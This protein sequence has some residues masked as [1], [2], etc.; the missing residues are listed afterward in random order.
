[1]QESFALVTYLTAI[2]ASVQLF[3]QFKHVCIDK[4][5]Q[6]QAYLILSKD[7]AWDWTDPMRYTQLE[8]IRVAQLNL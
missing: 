1:M 8:T 5:G 3:A 6:E 7:S 4:H 2:K